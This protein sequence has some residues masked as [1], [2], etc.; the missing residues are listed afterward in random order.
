MTIKCILKTINNNTKLKSIF[1]FKTN[2]RK[3]N[4]KYLLTYVLFM[5]KSGISYRMLNKNKIFI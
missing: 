3:Y 5:L 2:N 1:Y 4:I